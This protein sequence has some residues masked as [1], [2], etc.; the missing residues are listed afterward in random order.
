MTLLRGGREES[1]AVSGGAGANQRPV[2][3]YA[4]DGYGGVSDDLTFYGL[5][6]IHGRD[7]IE[8]AASELDA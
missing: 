3:D 6:P 7:G 5:D 2:S 1:R 8:D 4:S